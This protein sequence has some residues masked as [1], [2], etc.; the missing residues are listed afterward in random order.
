MRPT[1][2]TRT[3][4]SG[5]FNRWAAQRGTPIFYGDR[6]TAP[7]NRLTFEG[8]TLSE[9]QELLGSPE[10]CLV[11]SSDQTVGLIIAYL[12]DVAPNGR[13]TYLTEG[14]LRLLHRKTTG[15]A[16]DPAPGT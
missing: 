14:L 4:T 10:L 8:A 13:V 2:W 11:L 7:G 15:P 1:P 16:C 3:S 6:R 12:E 5:P 9:D